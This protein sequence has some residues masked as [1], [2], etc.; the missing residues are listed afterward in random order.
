MVSKI[1]MTYFTQELQSI[2]I[3]V[4][5]S[6]VLS[7]VLFVAVYIMSFTSKVEFEK[8]SAYECG[9]A[10][11]SETNYPFEVQFALIAIM[12]LLFDIEVLYLYPLVTSIMDLTFYDLISFSI[13]F[14]ILTVGIV[15]EISRQVMG[16]NVYGN[17]TKTI[18]K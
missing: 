16:M 17:L 3:F 15:F 18:L 11:F 4:V 14:L 5:A 8:S 13:F 12:F 6:L 1:N 9:F 10:P 7:L 2:F